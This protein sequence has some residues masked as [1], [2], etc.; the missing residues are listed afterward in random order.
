LEKPVVPRLFAGGDDFDWW[1]NKIDS[2]AT[3]AEWLAW[4]QNLPFGP[5]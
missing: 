4:S 3:F 1:Q 5:E 2:S